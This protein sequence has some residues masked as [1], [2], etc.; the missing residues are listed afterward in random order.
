MHIFGEFI[1]PDGFYSIQLIREGCDAGTAAHFSAALPFTTS[2]WGDSVT[3]CTTSPCG[4]P[5]GSID[6]VTDV[7]AGL[8]KF[9]NVETGA[10]KTRADVEPSIIDF[11]IHISDVTFV[12]DAFGGDPYPFEPS[13]S[14]ACP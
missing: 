6:V 10:T 13:T 11:V 5:D 12:L 14:I 2:K 1:V 7:T 4:P 8:D 3:D 9:M